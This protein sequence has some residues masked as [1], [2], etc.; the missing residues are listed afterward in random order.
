MASPTQPSFRNADS[1]W[2]AILEV[3]F[4]SP[5]TVVLKKREGITAEYWQGKDAE[6]E[7]PPGQSLYVKVPKTLA[8]RG[9]M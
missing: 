9:A 7:D 3:W 4:L 5:H 2:A 1:L 6:R 8:L